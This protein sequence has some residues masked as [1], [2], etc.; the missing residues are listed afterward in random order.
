MPFVTHLRISMKGQVMNSVQHD[1]ATAGCGRVMRW[2]HSEGGRG[3]DVS[4][5]PSLFSHGAG[6]GA[7]ILKRFSE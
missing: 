5:H 3:R 6:L 1:R 2:W 4:A 7:F